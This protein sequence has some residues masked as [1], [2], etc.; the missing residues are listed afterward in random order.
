MTARGR[1]PI[2]RWTNFFYMLDEKGKGYVEPDDVTSIIE[3]LRKGKY[4]SDEQLSEGQVCFRTLLEGFINAGENTNGSMTLEQWLEAVPKIV[5]G[6]PITEAPV[7]WTE[8]IDKF[9][10]MWDKNANGIIPKDD[11]VTLITNVT[12]SISQEFALNLHSQIPVPFTSANLQEMLW[13]WGS[14]LVAVPEDIYLNLILRERA[15]RAKQQAQ[16][17]V[18]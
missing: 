11:F 7:W 6:K 3:I 4:F 10:I 17:Q 9:F 16:A 12:Y 2:P 5:I 1:G 14:S 15:A 18:S 13:T 8:A